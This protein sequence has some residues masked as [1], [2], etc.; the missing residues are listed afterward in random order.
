MIIVHLFVANVNITL[1]NALLD[2][3]KFPSIATQGRQQLQRTRKVR[4]L[5]SRPPMKRTQH[6]CAYTPCVHEAPAPFQD[7]NISNKPKNVKLV[8]LECKRF[9]LTLERSYTQK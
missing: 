8:K 4:M 1:R 3:I 5:T 2:I 9:F 6:F 7:R